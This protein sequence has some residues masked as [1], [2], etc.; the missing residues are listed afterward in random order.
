MKQLD[1]F[2]LKIFYKTT[3]LYSSKISDMN[4]QKTL[5][6]SSVE[7]LQLNAIPDWKQNKNQKTKQNVINYITETWRNM[8]T[9]NIMYSNKSYL[10]DNQNGYVGEGPCPWVIYPI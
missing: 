2:K 8:N 9:D 6:N 7:T 5:R 1:K 3:V 10:Y 4:V